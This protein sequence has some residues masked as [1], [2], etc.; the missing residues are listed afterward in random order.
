MQRFDIKKNDTNKVTI[1]FGEYN[2]RQ[3]IEFREF[4]TKDGNKWFPTTKGCTIPIDSINDLKEGVA[5]L[6]DEPNSV[7][8]KKIK[9]E[10]DEDIP[11]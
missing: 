1:G 6:D 3:Y 9:R 11:F 7:P 2:G 5:L 4:F 8:I 10:V